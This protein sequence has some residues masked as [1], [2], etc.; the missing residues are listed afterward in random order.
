MNRGQ[1]PL[2]GTIIGTVGVILASAI[3][4]FATSNANLA[5]VRGDIN[6]AKQELKGDIGLVEERE[7]NHYSEIEKTLERME[8]KIDSLKK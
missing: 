8:K 5:D 3:T 2:I 6:T 4:S 1:I 7:K